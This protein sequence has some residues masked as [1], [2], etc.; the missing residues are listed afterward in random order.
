MKIFET[1]SIEKLAETV[2]QG[3]DVVVNFN[4]R[5]VELEDSSVFVYDSVYVE[6]GALY[7]DV[8]SVAKL[9][10]AKE[11]LKNTDFYMTVDKVESLTEEKKA[12]LISKRETAREVIRSIEG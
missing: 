6:N 11:Y 10:E 8:V 7:S 1:K 4:E 2:T 5:V 12:E 3:N 9:F